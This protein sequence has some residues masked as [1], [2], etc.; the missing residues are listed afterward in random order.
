MQQRGQEA[1][2]R[3]QEQTVGPIELAGR[4]RAK[5]AGRIAARSSDHDLPSGPIAI[6]DARHHLTFQRK[7][8]SGKSDPSSQ[9]Q[10]M[11][12]EA[13]SRADRSC[14]R[15]A[16]APSSWIMAGVA[17][18]R[19]KRQKKQEQPIVKGDGSTLRPIVAV[20]P[21]SAPP[22]HPDPGSTEIAA[23]KM[24]FGR[25]VRQRE[26]GSARGSAAS[27]LYWTENTFS[28]PFSRMLPCIGPWGG[29]L[30]L[31]RCAPRICF[32][33]KADPGDPG[34]HRGV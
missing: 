11:A 19:Q 24:A 15:R 18:N 9:K 5:D 14:P 22:G 26:A 13:A 32:M 6:S 12:S 8:D 1:A 34:S 7:A 30:S 17:R 25:V 2:A 23:N 21:G 27:S 20:D 16:S 33:H 31:A 29:A 28:R 3:H 4:R 10:G